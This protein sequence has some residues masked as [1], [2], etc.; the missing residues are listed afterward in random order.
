[1]VLHGENIEELEE[2]GPKR[3]VEGNEGRHGGMRCSW[4]PETLLVLHKDTH[5]H[6][7]IFLPVALSAEGIT[8][9][10]HMVS[11]VKWPRFKP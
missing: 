2:G 6:L 11:G 10:S 1:M 5:T 9:V 4:H 7:L 3:S 8:V